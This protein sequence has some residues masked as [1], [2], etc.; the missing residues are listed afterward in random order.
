MKMIRGSYVIDDLLQI[1]HS[2]DVFFVSSIEF[3]YVI[4]RNSI[5]TS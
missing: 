3:S 1:L 2:C 5:R 4:N